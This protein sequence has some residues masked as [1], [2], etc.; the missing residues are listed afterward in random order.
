MGRI[1]IP[2]DNMGVQH[3][4]VFQIASLFSLLAILTLTVM[5]FAEPSPRLCWGTAPFAA[6][7]AMAFQMTS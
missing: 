3:G 4:M 6:C 2:A 5:F 7:F 1:D